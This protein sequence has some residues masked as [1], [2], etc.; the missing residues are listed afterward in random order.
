M[1]VQTP[2]LRSGVWS[3]VVGGCAAIWWRFWGDIGQNVRVLNGVLRDYE[4]RQESEG[5]G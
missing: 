2:P 1:V 4:K 5:A 3:I